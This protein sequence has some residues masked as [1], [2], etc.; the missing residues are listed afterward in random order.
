MS[1][2]LEAAVKAWDQHWGDRYGDE[3]LEE[4]GEEVAVA[5]EAADAVL[6]SDEAVERTAKALHDLGVKD[7][8]Q[9]ENRDEAIRELY[10]ED[11]RAVI[12]GLK[13]AADV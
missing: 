4:M 13:Q 9:W 6:F 5:L 10:R 3:A 1:K 8:L 12:D 7:G 2:R 11:V